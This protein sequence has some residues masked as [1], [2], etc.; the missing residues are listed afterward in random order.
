MIQKKISELVEKEKIIDLDDRQN[1]VFIGDTHGDKQASEKI[2]NHFQEEVKAGETYLV[3]LGDYVD[4]GTESRENIDYL[5]SKKEKA[6]EGVILLL[7]NHDAYDLKNLRPADFWDSLSRDEY[8]YYKELSLLPW[9]AESSGLAASHGCLPFVENLDGLTQDL[10]DVFEKKNKYDLPIWVSTS[11]GDINEKIS[12]AQT[13]PL[14]GRPQ[15]GRDIILKEMQNHDWNVLIRAHQP[16]VQGWSFSEN[17]LTI[18]TSQVYVE[19]GRA[20]ER[21]L[22]IVDLDEGVDGSEDVELL[23]LENL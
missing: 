16:E 17:V 10:E 19:M 5:L 4:R 9:F 1:A 7:G 18:F 2:W 14:T 6:P 3:F 23:S 22:A 12:G 11:W 13:D 15:F 20:Y 8:E 21:S